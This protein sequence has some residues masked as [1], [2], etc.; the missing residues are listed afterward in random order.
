MEEPRKVADLDG[1]IENYNRILTKLKASGARGDIEAVALAGACVYIIAKMNYEAPDEFIDGI[2][3]MVK[4]MMGGK[5]KHLTGIVDLM[6]L[7]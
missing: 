6:L 7:S 2:R 3:K 4:Q 1:F 5:L